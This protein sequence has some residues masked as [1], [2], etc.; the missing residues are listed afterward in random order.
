MPPGVAT[1]GVAAKGVGVGVAVW[2]AGMGAAAV[3]VPVRSSPERGVH[4]GARVL[5]GVSVAP[6]SGGCWRQE[7]A[8]PTVSTINTSKPTTIRTICEMRS[9]AHHPRPAYRPP[10]TD[11]RP[12]TTDARTYFVNQATP[13]GIAY[14]LT[15]EAARLMNGE[16]EFAVITA[17][18]TAGNQRS[19]TASL[20]RIE[21]ATHEVGPLLVETRRLMLRLQGISERIDKLVADPSPSGIAALPPRL[22]ELGSELSASSRQLNRVLQRFE[23]SP[24]SF[25]LGWPERAPG[26]GE[27]GF[28]A[29]PWRPE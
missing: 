28:V 7:T 27:P 14:G 13:E 17:T 1:S 29:P 4:V 22:N 2:P 20:A 5:R 6:A 18:L 8:S 10:T 19:L 25:V 16:G 21:Q 15:D 24:Q 23:E 3:T 11:G 9:I 26:P 12:P